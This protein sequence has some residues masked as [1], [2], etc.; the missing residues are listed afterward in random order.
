MRTQHPDL[1]ARIAA[2]DL[3][4]VFEWLRTHI[5]SQASLWKTDEL[6][7]R[8]TGEPLNPAHFR[9]HLEWRYGLT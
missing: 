2:G 4:L 1:D 7:Q 5:W 8:A 9:A 6:V 3:S